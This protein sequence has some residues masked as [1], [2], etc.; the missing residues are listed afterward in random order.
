MAKASKNRVTSN[1]DVAKIAASEARSIALH[2]NRIVP[3]TTRRDPNSTKMLVTI[4]TMGLNGKPDGGTREVYTSDVFQ[5]HHQEGVKKSL[6]TTKS[7]D[8]A[9]AVKVKAK[10]PKAKAK[11]VRRARKTAVA[12]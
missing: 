7:A 12:V 10:A 4:R 2:G 6:K 5:V 1:D 9:K 11:P 3:G 8:K